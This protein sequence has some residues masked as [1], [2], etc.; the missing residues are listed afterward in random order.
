MWRCWAY[1]CSHGCL[2]LN[3]CDYVE[4]LF[5]C[6]RDHVEQH[7]MAF[8]IVMQSLSFRFVV[9]QWQITP[10]FRKKDHSTTMY[11]LSTGI[12]FFETKVV[13]ATHSGSSMDMRPLDAAQLCWRASLRFVTLRLKM[14]TI[15]INMTENWPS[16]LHLVFNHFGRNEVLVQ[17]LE[18]Y[19]AA[20]SDN[21]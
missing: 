8:L 3:T 13:K 20:A 19:T 15:F 5:L 16:L 11:V 10:P 1:H 7:W 2:S 9:H 14:S 6:Q 17:L 4:T 12:L 21:S 18:S